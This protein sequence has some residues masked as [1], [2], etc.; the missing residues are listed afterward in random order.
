MAQ[1]LTKHDLVDDYPY[2]TYAPDVDAHTG[3]VGATIEDNDGSLTANFTYDDVVNQLD[4]GRVFT[5]KMTSGDDVIYVTFMS[6]LVG[7]LPK[8]ITR[9]FGK[10]NRRKQKPGKH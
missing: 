7:P 1:Y 2:M 5:V 6:P 10:F 4:N 8:Y 3:N 9:Y